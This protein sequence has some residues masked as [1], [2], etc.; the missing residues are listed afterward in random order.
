MRI[1]LKHKAKQTLRDNG[2]WFV[3]F[4]IMYWV[5]YFVVSSVPATIS[6]VFFPLV[7]IFLI[8]I[9]VLTIGVEMAY[10]RSLMVK[11]NQRPVKIHRD[12][13]WPIFKNSPRFAWAEILKG[14]YI[15]MWSLLFFFPGAYKGLAYSQTSYLLIDF[16]LLTANE[17]I[18]E[19]RRLMRGRKLRFIW[20]NMRFIGWYIIVMITFG[21]AYIYVKPYHTLALINFYEEALE[22]K[23]YPEKVNTY[24]QRREAPFTKTQSAK[25]RAFV[26]NRKASQQDKTNRRQA[27]RPYRSSFYEENRR[28]R[29][30]DQ[31]D[32]DWNDF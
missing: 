7:V 26:Y 1:D 28:S 11:N 27:R 17:A 10:V 2:A 5:A 23:G 12:I 16:P 21:L 31:V 29:V 3:I 9:T 13:L 6:I 24:S 8:I 18:T 30:Q 14:F 20:L 15:L 19:S 32:D 4:T 22:E 25:E